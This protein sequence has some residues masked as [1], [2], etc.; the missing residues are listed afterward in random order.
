MSKVIIKVKKLVPEALL[1]RRAHFDD[2]GADIFAISRKT[3]V[4]G[5]HRDVVQYGFGIA[6]EFPVGYSVLMLPRSSVY[7][8]GMWLCNSMGLFDSGYRGEYLANFYVDSDCK[9]YEVSK[10]K[11]LPIAQ[12]V[13]PECLATEVEFVEVD[14]LSPSERG[15]GGLGSTDG[16]NK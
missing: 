3:V 12:L 9:P 4:Y 10:E 5:E 11:P 13:V 7:K 1:P 2:K 14:E 8:T 6:L 15:T 16:K